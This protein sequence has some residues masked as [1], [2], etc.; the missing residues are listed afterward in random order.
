MNGAR[1]DRPGAGTTAPVGDRKRLVEVELEDIDPRVARP[2]DPHDRI[3]V[4][5]IAVDLPTLAVNDLRDLGDML[6]EEA[7]GVG[8]GHH[9][10]GDLLIHD[11]G[12]RA[13]FHAPLRAR[14]NLDDLV[15]ADRRTGR[16]G[17]MS[18][19]GDQDTLTRV[20]S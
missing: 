14:F 1:W 5:A 18:G 9:D 13:R 3:Q 20:P 12:H 6:L 7:Q 16:I 2:G 11:L 19:I 17:A 4:G 8:V 10:G 15:A